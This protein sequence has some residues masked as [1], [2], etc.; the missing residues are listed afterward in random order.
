MAVVCASCGFD[1]PPGM[2]FCGNCGSPLVSVPAQPAQAD[3]PIQPYS[4]QFGTMMG[5]DLIE[6][7][8][9]A[10]LTSSGQRRNVT[11]LFADISGSTALA[12]QID[13]EDLYEILQDTIRVLAN[14][15]YKYEGVVDKIIG[16]GLMALFGAPI[17]HENNAERAV[18]AAM[19]MQNDLHQLSKRLWTEK[20]V[21]LSVRIG[22][23]SGPVIIGGFGS[24]DLVL[25]YTAVGDTVNLAHRIEEAAPPGTIL[26]S[27]SV[28]RQVR[29]LFDCKQISVLNPKGITHPVTAYQVHGLKTRPGS[30]RGIEGFSAPMV[31]RDQELVVLKR[32]VEDLISSARGHF[33]LITG[34][35]GLGKSRL[36]AELKAS[37]DQS[38]LKLLEGQS[39]AY[40]HVSYWLVRD[41]LYSYLKL[42]S[43]S[44]PLQIRERLTRMIYQKMGAQAVDAIPFLEHLMLLPYSDVET[45]AR[46]Q[47][48]DAVQL[49][50][51][52]FLTIRDLVSIEADIQPLVI[53]LD[54]LHWADEA[55]LEL[56]EFL[57][58]LLRHKP[59]LILAISRSVQSRELERIVSWAKQNLGE[60]NHEI[61]L[62]HLSPESSKQLLSLLLSIPDLPEDLRDQ[63]LTRSAGIPFYLEEILRTL[64]D[65]GLISSQTGRWQIVPG[66]GG[67]NLGVPDTLKDLILTRFDRLQP[68]QRQVL[69]VAS[70]IGKEFSLPILGAVLRGLDAPDL[71]PAIDLLVDRE[72]IQPNPNSPET[73]FTFRHVLMSDAIYGTLLRKESSALHGQVA[74]AI[75]RMYLDRQEE[76]VE[77]LAN[78]YRMSN[79]SDRALHYLL[80]AGQKAIRNQAN[81]QAR[82]YFETALE[83]LPKA[84]PSGY[85]RY[86]AQSGMG[87]VLLFIGEY[88]EARDYFL[89]AFQTLA[90]EQKNYQEKSALQ[91][92]IARTY[93]RLGEYDQAQ[94]Q[95][96]AALETLKAEPESFPAE[97]AQAWNDLAWIDFRRGNFAEADQLLQNA[98]ALVEGSDAY[99]VIAS[100]YNRLGGVAYNQGN[101]EQA[102]DYLRKSISIREASRDRVNL[103]TS[104]NNLGLLETEMGQFERALATLTRS[105]ELKSRLGQSEGIA[106]VLNNLGWINIQRNNLDEA[107]R[108]LDKALE[109]TQQ[110][111]YSS[112]HCQV[113]TT[114][115]EMYQA[116]GEWDRANKVLMEAE[117]TIRD[118]GSDDQRAEIYRQLGE[119]A[120]GRG[121]METALGWVSKAG[122]LLDSLDDEAKSRT[123]LQRAEYLRLCGRLATF[124]HEYSSAETYLADSQAIF[125]EMRSLLGRGRVLYCQGEFENARG[126]MKLAQERFRQAYELFQSIGA[127][128]EANRTLEKIA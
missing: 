8:R 59:I 90:S 95:I 118:I 80:L 1:N 33:A 14:N 87:D 82:Q 123:L 126:N 85:Q 10:G 34:E 20:D 9:S 54:D 22:L 113:L 105:Y 84:Q 115:G 104:L 112:L 36:T 58:D 63:I 67:A 64:I 114:I 121:E 32:A 26:I 41:L 103:A 4:R 45:E 42:P 73:E 39:L 62:Q 122:R 111:G 5:V 24:D 27:E 37:L 91:I 28:Y 117:L 75:E 127:S 116:G 109:L 97:R 125:E 47:H 76:H 99:E 107:Q 46:L 79:N 3:Q 50:Q 83:L 31:G 93:E 72:F 78:H 77:V 23:H 124:Q 110:I 92:K 108:V 102:A 43:T 17:S 21:D 70:V 57:L 71:H 7:M 68:D 66:L 35:A 100:I 69:Q 86:L 16:D 38:Q 106:M 65:Q 96:A 52:T 74:E 56:I 81:Q 88:P 94:S 18:R 101:W 55:S 128:L 2:R 49:R 98:L 13:S 120:L 48:M 60:R 53:V 89:Q 40:R 6:R 25:N 51:Q 119:A 12:E 11:I 44:P 19:D 29:V 30:V 15:V 61:P